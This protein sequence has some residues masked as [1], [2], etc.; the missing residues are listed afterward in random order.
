M[1]ECICVFVVSLFTAV[2]LLQSEA[3]KVLIACG[4]R[5]D[6]ESVIFTHMCLHTCTCMCVHVCIKL[7]CMYSVEQRAELIN[8]A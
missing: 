7:I 5:V 8:V 3:Q 6:S 4:Q 1:C 2:Y